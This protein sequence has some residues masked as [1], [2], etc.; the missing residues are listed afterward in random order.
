MAKTLWRAVVVALCAGLVLAGCGSTTTSSH[1]T[2]TPTTSAT[3][4]QAT[5]TRPTAA[6]KA[7][8]EQFGAAAG[9]VPGNNLTGSVTLQDFR[10]YG[11]LVDR[12]MQT[13]YGPGSALVT[14]ANEDLNSL[15]AIGPVSDQQLA[16]VDRDAAALGTFCG[17]VS[18]AP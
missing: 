3:T 16:L 4:T 5:Q 14:K 6:V 11:Q 9:S 8:C 2:S 10:Q 1:Q 7:A 18:M 17:Q 13:V 12:L 15:P